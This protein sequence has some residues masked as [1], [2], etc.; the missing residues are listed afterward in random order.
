MLVKMFLNLWER[1]N[2]DIV[3]FLPSRSNPS[4]CNKTIEVLY[5]SCASVE[6]FDIVCIVDD[7]EIDLYESTSVPFTYSFITVPLYVPTIL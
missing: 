2:K 6:N 7:D 1:M 3:I 5:S 4:G